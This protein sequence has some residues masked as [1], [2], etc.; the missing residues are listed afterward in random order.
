MI[1]NLDE[2]AIPLRAAVVFVVEDNADNLFIVEELLR[3]AGVSICRALTSGR[4]LFE[5]IETWA[6]PIHLILLDLQMPQEDGYAILT[7]L[8]TIPA[9]QATQV[10]VMTANVLADDMAKARAAGF[11]GFIGKPLNY[12]RFPQQITRILAGEAVWEAR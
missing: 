8:R 7:R 4:R 5:L 11:D 3:R 2:G 1:T 6:G 12:H 10:V 9:L